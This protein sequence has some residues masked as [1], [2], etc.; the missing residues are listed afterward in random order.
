MG[1]GACVWREPGQCRVG[2]AEPTMGRGNVREYQ[3][4]GKT[5]LL[6]CGV[7][8]HVV[9]CQSGKWVLPA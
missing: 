9:T 6:C 4:S 2:R 7:G 1:L 8:S 5:D 3:D